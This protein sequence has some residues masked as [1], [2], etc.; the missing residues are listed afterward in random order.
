MVNILQIV[1][2]FES[3]L[4]SFRDHFIITVNDVKWMG[5]NDDGPKYGDSIFIANDGFDKTSEIT[6]NSNTNRYVMSKLRD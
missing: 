4:Y 5:L 6:I 2:Y 3:T 1:C